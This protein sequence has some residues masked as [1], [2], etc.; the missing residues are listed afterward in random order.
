V[1]ILDPEGSQFPPWQEYRFRTWELERWFDGRKRTLVPNKDFPADIPF[2]E[3]KRRLEKAA[4]NRGG[5][6]RV[7][8]EPNDHVGVLLTP[9]WETKKD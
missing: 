4:Y 3:L 2:E 6:A 9:P 8:R 7:W 5:S 1:A